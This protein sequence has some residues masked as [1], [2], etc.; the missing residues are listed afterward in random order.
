MTASAPA[1]ARV[2]LAKKGEAGATKP[3]TA[4][5]APGRVDALALVLARNDFYQ[6]NAERT[7]LIVLG[8]IVLIASL[9]AVIVRLF[10]F[11]DSR[12]YFFPVQNDNTL[13]LER[14]L[15]EP[16]FS[17]E[18]IRAWAERAVTRTL[19]F[20]YYDHLLR[21]QNSRIYFTNRGWATFMQALADAQIL[22]R[23][24]AVKSDQIIG[25][26][27]VVTTSMRGGRR[28]T[29][30]NQGVLGWYYSW[31]VELQINAAF[32]EGNLQTSTPWRVQVLIV[33]VPAME[34]REGIG[35]D[36]LVATR[37]IP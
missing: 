33:R 27:M 3:A 6:T 34:S 22:E 31:Q 5:P 36:Q 21:L 9:I 10:D 23:I 20:G 26:N 25:R 15:S 12:D 24:N 13:I 32:L 37:A 1:P 11:T 16:V 29:I 35:I 14:P 2:S 18:Q 28:A 4:A 17:D 8:Q 19:T 7:L 30:T